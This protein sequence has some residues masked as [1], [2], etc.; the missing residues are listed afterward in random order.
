MRHISRFTS[1]VFGLA[2]ALLAS[3]S[4]STVMATTYVRALAAAYDQNTA[5]NT[6]DT[7]QIAGPLAFAQSGP[8]A[9]YGGSFYAKAYAQFDPL[10]GPVLGTYSTVNNTY[11]LY[12]AFTPAEAW[13]SETFTVTGTPGTQVSFNLGFRLHDTLSGTK[14]PGFPDNL[15]VQ[16]VAYLNGT[17]AAAGLSIHDLLTSPAATKT[18]R[19]GLRP[20]S[21]GA[22]T[23]RLAAISPASAAEIRTRRAGLTRASAAATATPLAR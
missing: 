23:T 1:V 13:W 10:L 7:G 22:I 16:A 4:A 3:A 5:F 2:T 15:G 6:Q 17:G 8:F 21:A 12:Q 19:A 14:Y 20:A 9:D 18:R 11:P